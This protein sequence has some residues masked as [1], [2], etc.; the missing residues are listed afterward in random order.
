MVN[1][2]GVENLRYII[3]NHW[4]LIVKT[5]PIP[6]SRNHRIVGFE[7]EPRSYAPGENVNLE[8]KQHKALYLDDLLKLEGDKRKF[9][10]TY[11]IQTVVTK[12]TMWSNRMDHYMKFG[13]ENIHLAAILLSLG[14]IVTLAVILCGIMKRGLN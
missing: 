14:I 6:E 9:D 8:F 12:E 13:N 3:Y 11:S 10:F 7:V 5:S 2:G 4:N 1:N